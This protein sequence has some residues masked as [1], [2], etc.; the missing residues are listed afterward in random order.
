VP[1]EMFFSV[2]LG[3]LGLCLDELVDLYACWW[4]AGSTQSGAVW[5]DSALY[6]LWCLWKE[7]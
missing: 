7:K 4:I 3:C 6:L 5:K 1:Y 2:A